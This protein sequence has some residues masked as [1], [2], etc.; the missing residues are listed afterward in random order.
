MSQRKWLI[1]NAER[2]L[3]TVAVFAWVWSPTPSVILGLDP[4]IHDGIG[5]DPRIK[6][7][8]DKKEEAKPTHN[9]L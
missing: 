9:P 3:L 1:R 4:R 7:E 8:D 6:S 5:V 2:N